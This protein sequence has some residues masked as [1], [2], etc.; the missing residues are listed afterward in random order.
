MASVMT[1]KVRR[2]WDGGEFF[3]AGTLDLEEVRRLLTD[4]EEVYDQ[5]PEDEDWE[6]VL[7]GTDIGYWRY[8]P[9]S[10]RSCGEHGWHLLPAKKGDRGTVFPG[11][12][13]DSWEFKILEFGCD[14][15]LTAL[16]PVEETV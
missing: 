6:L 15:P 13:V 7:K 9:C 1:I 11:V 14:D 16:G 3:V 12:L 8:V 10:P 4:H 5:A 2:L